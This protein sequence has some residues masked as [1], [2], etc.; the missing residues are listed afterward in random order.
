MTEYIYSEGECAQL[1]QFASA[2]W[3]DSKAVLRRSGDIEFIDL[4]DYPVF[5]HL[6]AGPL[7]HDKIL[8]REEY[9]IALRELETRMYD[10]GA[11][12]TGQSGIGKI[13]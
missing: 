7:F 12:V 1:K 11:Y 3:G 13:V 10:R 8:V 6:F 5:R 4:K 9:R 2:V